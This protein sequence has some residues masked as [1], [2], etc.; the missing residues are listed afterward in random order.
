M[1]LLIEIAHL[2]QMYSH[3]H[4]IERLYRLQRYLDDQ[5]LLM[6]QAS[7]NLGELLHGPGEY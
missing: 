2:A 7:R 6:R 3:Q 4:L 1:P 5:S